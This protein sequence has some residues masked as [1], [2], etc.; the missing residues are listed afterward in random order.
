[1]LLSHFEALGPPEPADRT[2]PVLRGKEGL[3]MQGRVRFLFVLLSAGTAGMPG[4][5]NAL[6]AL[7]DEDCGEP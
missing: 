1:M 4:D 3:S 6:G 7:C 2:L 5:L